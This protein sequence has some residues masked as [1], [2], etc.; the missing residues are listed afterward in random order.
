RLA[1][2]PRDSIRG[3]NGSNHKTPMSTPSI[4]E[5][6]FDWPLCYD[7]ENFILSSIEE[8][9]KRNGFARRLAERMSSETGT[10]LLD[11]VDHLVLAAN[12]QKDLQRV[13]YVVDPLGETPPHLK[14][15]WHP[16][17]MLP[18]VLIE[19]EAS[20]N[21]DGPFVLAIR[22]ESVAD[23]IVAHGL[24]QEPEGA[25]FSRYRRVR[26]SVEGGT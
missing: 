26:V 7:A 21:V 1:A 5:K 12:R 10:L 8:F 25:P 14:A 19:R 20:A 16:D 24:D 2:G 11:W 15:F 9:T 13:G 4:K 18:R 17:A 22:C 6:R 3:M 23:F